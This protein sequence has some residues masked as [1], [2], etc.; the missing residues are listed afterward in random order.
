MKYFKALPCDTPD[1]VILNE[2]IP[3]ISS[4]IGTS[5]FAE[6]L[7]YAVREKNNGTI[8]AHININANL[9]GGKYQLSEEKANAFITNWYGNIE[10][11]NFSD[12]E[13]GMKFMSEVISEIVD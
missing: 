3:N 13:L 12:E 10:Y 4:L 9:F 6:S 8:N 7:G 11:R 5:D 1:E 2:A